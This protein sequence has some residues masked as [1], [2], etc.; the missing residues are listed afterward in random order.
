MHAETVSNHRSEV[1]PVFYVANY[2]EWKAVILGKF[3]RDQTAGW[4]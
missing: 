2:S 4:E 1:T 3:H